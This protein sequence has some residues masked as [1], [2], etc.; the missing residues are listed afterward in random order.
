MSAE[1]LQAGL[2]A[3]LALQGMRG[4]ALVDR[5]TGMVVQSAGTPELLP[6]AEAASDYWRLCGRQPVFGSLGGLRGQ[7]VIHEHA[8][9]TLVPCGE[10]LLLVTLSDE[11]AGVDWERWRRCALELRQLACEL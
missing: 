7:A 3:V 4:C 2:Q 6:M 8:R 5:D 9:V 1:Q 11:V 10:G